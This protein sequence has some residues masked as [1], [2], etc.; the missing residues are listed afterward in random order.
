MATQRVKSPHFL[1]KHIH[2]FWIKSRNLNLFLT[3]LIISRY[4]LTNDV[5]ISAYHCQKIDYNLKNGIKCT[6][7]EYCCEWDV[8]C[9][10]FLF[11][12]KTKY[13]TPI[14]QKSPPP[15]VE[16]KFLAKIGAL[17]LVNNRWKYIKHS[18]TK[19]NSFLLH[20]IKNWDFSSGE[21][22]IRVRTI[23][24]SVIIKTKP[25]KRSERKREGE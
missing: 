20:V 19:Q 10:W 13:F 8:I 24:V 5:I 11:P 16:F 6:H 9:E 3:S 14:A 2:T 22:L 15:S 1:T 21:K 17:N 4:F 18:K 12:L 23:R 25:N 7:L